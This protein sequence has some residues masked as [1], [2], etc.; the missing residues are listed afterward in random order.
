[1]LPAGF[2]FLMLMMTD[3]S[4]L[5]NSILLLWRIPGLWGSAWLEIAPFSLISGSIP[6]AEWECM[7]QWGCM[8]GVS[9]AIEGGGAAVP[10]CMELSVLCRRLYCPF[11][12]SDSL[13]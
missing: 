1:M 4:E 3:P 6:N 11:V 12:H 13:L 9:S 2:I 8:L 7:F 5:H 10:V